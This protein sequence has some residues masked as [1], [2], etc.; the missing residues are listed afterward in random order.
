MGNLVDFVKDLVEQLLGHRFVP[1]SLRK[2]FR[3]ENQH[4]IPDRKLSSPAG[5]SLGRLAGDARLPME[6]PDKGNC[7]VVDIHNVSDVHQKNSVAVGPSRSKN[8]CYQSTMEPRLLLRL[9]LRD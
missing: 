7:P 5:A 2:E 3:P 1:T 8:G 4:E 9:E 6:P